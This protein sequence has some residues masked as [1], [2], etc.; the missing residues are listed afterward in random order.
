LDQRSSVYVKAR[1]VPKPEA[2]EYW[3]VDCLEQSQS[4]VS[5]KACIGCWANL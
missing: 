4:S 2:Y 1:I 5:V 3:S